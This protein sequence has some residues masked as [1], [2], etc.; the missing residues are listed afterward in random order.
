ML[1]CP[2]KK[3]YLIGRKCKLVSDK[4]STENGY[5]PED[6]KLIRRTCLYAATKL[7]DLREEVVVVGGLVPSLLVDEG[8]PEDEYKSD[9]SSHVQLNLSFTF[10][11]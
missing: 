3:S 11:D 7:G 4:P 10:L 2:S 6:L 9:L 1:P 5:V 8:Q